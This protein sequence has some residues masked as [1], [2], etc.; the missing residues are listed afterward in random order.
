KLELASRD[1]VSRA[2]ATEILEGRDVDGCV[3]LDLPHLGPERILEPRP[4]IRELSVAF[5][6]VDPIDDPIP[7]RPG[8]HYHMGGVHVDIW[9]AAPHMPGLFAAGAR[10]CV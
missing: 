3:F 2:E 8:A 1:V 5:A 6:G 10:S 7:I 4:Q 9:G